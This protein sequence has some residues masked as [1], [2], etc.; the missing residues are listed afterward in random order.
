MRLQHCGLMPEVW[1]DNDLRLCL[2]DRAMDVLRA[3]RLAR[4]DIEPL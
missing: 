2:S 3:Y 4:C 1:L